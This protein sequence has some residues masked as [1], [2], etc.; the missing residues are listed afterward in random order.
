MRIEE[1][2]R[3]R[4][5]KSAGAGFAGGALML[6]SGVF[7]QQI[8]T[9]VSPSN[10]ETRMGRPA[11]GFVYDVT[12]FGAKADGRAVDSPAINRAI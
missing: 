4:F 2:G 9:L 10:G 7:G 8:P 5:L 11:R 1:S 3:R 6:P 12:A